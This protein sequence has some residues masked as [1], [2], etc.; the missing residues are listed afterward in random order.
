MK[1][2]IIVD[3]QNDFIPG[4]ALA[5]HEGDQIVP[6]INQIQQEFDFIVATQDWHPA[7][8]GSFAANHDGKNIGDFIDL[9]GVQQIL[10]PVHCVQGSFGADFH[11][12]LKRENWKAVFRKGTNPKVDS[13]SGFFDN[14]RQGDTGLSSYLK[15]NEIEEIYVCGLAADYCVK[16]TVL[17]GISEGFKTHLVIDATK[18]VNLQPDDFD[19]SVQEMKSAGA[20]LVSSHDICYK[21]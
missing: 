6:V 15:D 5:V 1:A 8:H 7:D 18:A 19:K 20:L 9:N 3:V 10:W 12:D 16:F 13:Y 17:D 4:G 14:N 11:A 2:L 21:K